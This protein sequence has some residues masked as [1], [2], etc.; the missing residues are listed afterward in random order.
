MQD[1]HVIVIGLN[2]GSYGIANS[3]PSMLTAMAMWWWKEETILLS[4]N[5]IK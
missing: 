2:Q 1:C 4:C 5:G 3:S